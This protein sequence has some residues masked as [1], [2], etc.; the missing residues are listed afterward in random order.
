MLH[1]LPLTGIDFLLKDEH[2]LRHL[3][4]GKIGLLTNQSALT[5]EYIPTAQA[6]SEKLKGALTCV[7]TPEHGWS[8][9]I[10]EGV[11][12]NDGFD[13]HLQLPIFSLYGESKK[14]LR[15][16][17]ID[18]LII[19]LQDVGLR[20]YTY[21][22]TCAKVLEA[23]AGSLLEILV[24]DR[25]N[26]LGAGRKGPTLDPN[27]RSFVGYLDV[28]FQHGQ[29]IGELLFPYNQS[30]KLSL[31]VIPCQHNHT[32]YKYPWI[33]PSPNLPSWDSVLLYPAL[34][35]LE[36]TNISEGRGT[37]LPFTCLG[38]P[39][40]DHHKLVDFINRMGGIRARPLIFTPQSGELKGKECQGA[41]LFITD[42]SKL[43]A[44]SL[45][46]KILEFLRE[47]YSPFE[48]TEMCDGKRGYFIDYLLGTD[49]YRI[50]P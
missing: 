12:V 47:H 27:F 15:E 24:C 4:K 23:C 30:L 37:S 8:G 21:A 5:K 28:P 42:L 35:L 16:I 40:L 13:S 48:W 43:D 26:P 44:F 7:L 14:S 50:S 1:N 25:P 41:Q 33:P 20:C 34:V 17:N 11:K 18:T 31:T 39:G 3:S 32:P 22:T 49:S 38:A 6:L 9:F 10:P 19:D 36:G 46:L 45:G 29:T 2:L